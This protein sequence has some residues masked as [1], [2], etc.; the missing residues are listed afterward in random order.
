MISYEL[1]KDQI[2]KNESYWKLMLWMDRLRSLE[3][4]YEVGF[5][6]DKVNKEIRALQTL[7]LKRDLIVKLY[8]Y[9]L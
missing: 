5:W 6:F 7:N 3:N 4:K 8:K 1:I 2:V 9:A